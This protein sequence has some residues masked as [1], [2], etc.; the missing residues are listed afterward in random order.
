MKVICI[1]VPSPIDGMQ[2]DSSPWVTVDRD[3]TVVSV[4][5]EVGGR[6]KVQLLNDTQS[7]GWFNANCFLTVDSTIP[8]NWVARVGEG[9]AL[10]LAPAAWLEEGFWERFYDADPDAHE[11]VERELTIIRSTAR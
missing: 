5:A 11:S 9:G 2:L 10:R 1:R 7:L 6:V 8:A 3:Y 4:L